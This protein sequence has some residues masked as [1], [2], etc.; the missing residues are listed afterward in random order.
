MKTDVKIMVS[1]EQKEMIQKQAQRRKMNVSDYLYDIIAP[2]VG[3]AKSDKL[4]ELHR[5]VESDI[6]NLALDLENAVKKGRIIDG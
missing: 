2:S 1:A 3:F 5:C 4:S 6:E